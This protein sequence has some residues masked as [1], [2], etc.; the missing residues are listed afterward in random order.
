[1]KL[2]SK[3]NPVLIYTQFKI[4]NLTQYHFIFN[5]GLLEILIS[6]KNKTIR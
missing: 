5:L 6:E 3:F 4:N 1:M 2:E